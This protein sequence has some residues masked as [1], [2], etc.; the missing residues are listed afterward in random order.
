MTR[1]VKGHPKLEWIKPPGRRNEALD[2]A[3]YALA[4]AH[5]VG[6]DR[7]KEGDWSKWQHRVEPP[8]QEKPEA[9][10]ELPKPTRRKRGTFASSKGWSRM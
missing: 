7:W 6:I 10:A 2:C 4:A 8:Q 9:P 5:F 1:Y 3:V